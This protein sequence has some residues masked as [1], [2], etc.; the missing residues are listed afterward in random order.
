MSK[1]RNMNKLTRVKVKVVNDTTIP[2]HE[3]KGYREVEG[4]SKSSRLVVLI[5]LLLPMF[6]CGTH[7]FYVGKIGTGILYLLTFGWFGIGL[8]FDLI[9][10][11]QGTFQD[12]YGRTITKW[13]VD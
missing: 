3:D 7:R 2:I 5:L 6:G 1:L 11:L 4:E 8:L 12:C 13:L 10:I 9:K